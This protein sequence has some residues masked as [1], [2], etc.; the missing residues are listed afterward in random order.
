MELPDEVESPPG[1]TPASLA[2]QAARCLANQLI[3][4]TLP[5]ITK[6]WEGNIKPKENIRSVR[7]KFPNKRTLIVSHLLCIYLY[8]I[9]DF[10]L[11]FL[12][13]CYTYSS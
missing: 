4:T 1:Q 7:K 2:K 13:I 9:C 12:L 3:Q 8:C 11:I 5:A 6:Y 10:L